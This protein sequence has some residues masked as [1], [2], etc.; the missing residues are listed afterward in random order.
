MIRLKI[1]MMQVVLMISEKEK[2]KIINNYKY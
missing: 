2:G 1:Q